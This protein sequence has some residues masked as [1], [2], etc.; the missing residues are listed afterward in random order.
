MRHGRGAFRGG[1]PVFC[2]LSDCHKN[3]NIWCLGDTPSQSA[4]QP[5]NKGFVGGGVGFFQTRLW[6]LCLGLAE[7]T[8]K[9]WLQKTA[10]RARATKSQTKMRVLVFPTIFKG[11]KLPC[12]FII[13]RREQ[14]PNSQAFMASFEASGKF[15][16]A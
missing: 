5:K 14:F 4:K 15:S 6:A 8:L 11:A 7:R 1:S 13:S 3:Y 12:A 9:C 2:P 16:R 10:P